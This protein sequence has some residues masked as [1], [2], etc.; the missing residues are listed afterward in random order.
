[1][2]VNTKILSLNVSSSYDKQYL[3]SKIRFRIIAKNDV[4]IMVPYFPF[5]DH[6][7]PEVISTSDDIFEK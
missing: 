6:G 5:D 3:Y 1:M 2:L 7:F 4:D